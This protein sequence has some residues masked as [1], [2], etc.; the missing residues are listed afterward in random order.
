MSCCKKERKTEQTCCEDK[1]DEKA[2]KVA[3]DVSRSGCGCSCD[4]SKEPAPKKV[5]KK[6]ASCC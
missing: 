4:S 2:A 3:E 5:E 1:V 6:E